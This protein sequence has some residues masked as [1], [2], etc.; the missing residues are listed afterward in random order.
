MP[1]WAWAIYWVVYAMFLVWWWRWMRRRA[2][3][4]R[5]ALQAL[6]NSYQSGY[7]GYSRA[8]SWSWYD[9][10]PYPENCWVTGEELDPPKPPEPCECPWICEC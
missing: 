5:E 1:L 7:H 9:D 3:A 10:E 4:R 6:I 8:V 2:K